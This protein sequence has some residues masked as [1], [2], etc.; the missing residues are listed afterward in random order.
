M[1]GRGAWIKSMNMHS[2]DLG[3]D[4]IDGGAAP[5]NVGYQL[6]IGDV[7]LVIRL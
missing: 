4:L 1:H 7:S 6:E 3:L 5:E 2:R